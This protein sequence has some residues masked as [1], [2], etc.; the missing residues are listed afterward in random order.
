M[1]ALVKNPTATFLLCLSSIHLIISVTADRT[2]AC[3][4]P[5]ESA[6]IPFSMIL[7]ND[8]EDGS[9]GS[10]YDGSPGSNVFWAIESHDTF[11]GS[12][13]P[14]PTC[15]S[16]YLRISRNPNLSLFGLAVLRSKPILAS[17]GEEIHFK[18]WIRS[19]RPVGNN[20][21]VLVFPILFFRN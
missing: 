3:S 8:F 18:F 21:E 17:P 20:L 12:L 7:I 9:F 15:G 11:F 10:W 16:K 2:V 4:E 1:L 19:R 14:F 6:S 5:D 13:V